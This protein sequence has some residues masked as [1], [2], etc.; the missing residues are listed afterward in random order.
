MYEHFSRTLRSTGS[1]MKTTTAQSLSFQNGKD[2]LPIQS[3]Q[4]NK[5][6]AKAGEHYRIVKRKG[7]ETQ[8]LGDV[9][10][11]K[12]G[13]D[14][15]LSY[16]D[17]TRVTLEN[18]YGECA[19]ATA[20]DLTL[21]GNDPDGYSLN[22][23]SLASETLG[24]DGSSLLYAHGNRDVLIGMAQGNSALLSTLSGIEGAEITYIPAASSGISSLGLLGLGLL[25]GAVLIG[26]TGGSSNSGGANTGTSGTSTPSTEPPSTATPDASHVV[27]GTIIAGPVIAGHSLT[28][29]LYKAD[30]T[31][32]LGTG[33]VDATGSFSIDV[34][35]YTGAVIAKVVDAS[36][37]PD[38]MD[39]ATGAAKDLNANL[40]AVAVVAGGVTTMNINPVTTIAAIKAGLAADGS[41]SVSSASVLEAN[42]AVGAAFGVENIITT[43][44]ATTVD[45]NGSANPSYNPA[46]GVISASEK[47]GALL[48]VLSGN[49][50]G[51]AGNMQATI[52]NYAFSITGTAAASTLD[53]AG[54]A[55]FERG[56]AA[57]KQRT[58]GDVASIFDTSPPV[59]SIS[60][61]A[62]E[63]AKAEGGNLL[64]NQE[65]SF[66]ICRSNGNTA[67]SVDYVITGVPDS[68]GRVGAEVSDFGLGTNVFMPS[69]TVNFAAG[70]I[71]KVISIRVAGDSATEWDEKFA[72]TLKS[73]TGGI[74]DSNAS[75]QATILNDD[76][77]ALGLFSRMGEH[78]IGDRSKLNSSTNMVEL[79]DTAGEYRTLFEMSAASYL[80]IQELAR[81]PGMEAKTELQLKSEA[82]LLKLNS[83]ADLKRIGM[84]FSISAEDLGL[85]L[86]AVDAGSGIHYANG[87]YSSFDDTRIDESSVALIGRSDDALFLAFRGTDIFG[88]MIADPFFMDLHYNEYQPLFSGISNYLLANRNITDVFITGHSLGGEMA[89]LFMQTHLD[90]AGLKY[91]SITFEA[92]NKL[93]GDNTQDSRAINFEMRDDTVPDLAVF[94]YGN[95]G[96][97]VYMDYEEPYG[98][99]LGAVYLISNAHYM[100]NLDDQI[101]RVFNRIEA[102][103]LMPNSARIYVDDNND[104][105]IVTNSGTD[106][107]IGSVEDAVEYADTAYSVNTV[108]SS[109]GSCLVIQPLTDRP[110]G[111]YELSEK[112]VQTVILSSNTNL[113]INA[114]VADH[115]LLLVGSGGNNFII[116]SSHDDILVGSGDKDL[117]CGGV[118][119]DVLYGGN[120]NNLYGIFN[121]P[122]V[123][124]PWESAPIANH[125]EIQK[126]LDDYA[127]K[128]ILDDVSYLCGGGGLDTLVGSNDNDYFFIDV[129]KDNNT[130]NTDT[131]V[132]FESSIDHDYLIFSAAQLGIDASKLNAWGWGYQTIGLEDSWQNRPGSLVA[133]QAPD[134]F[135]AHSDYEEHFFKVASIADYKINPSNHYLNDGDNLTMFVDPADEKPAFVLDES[136][137]D[138]YFDADGNMDYGDQ[139]LVA[140][141]SPSVTSSFDASRLL[142]LPTFGVFSKDL[143][144]SPSSDLPINNNPVGTVSFSGV[145]AQNQT[146]TASNNL[147]DADGL[148]GVG[149]L[150]QISADGVSGWSNIGTNASTLSVTANALN[151][152]LRVLAQYT[153]NLGTSET[154]ISASQFIPPDTTLPVVT[155]TNTTTGTATGPIVY[156]FTFSEAV[157]GFTIDDIALS[158][159]T[160]TGFVAVDDRHYT[161]TVNPPAGSGNLMVGVLPDAVLDASGNANIGTTSEPQAYA[162]ADVSPTVYSHNGHT[163]MLTTQPMTWTQAEA[164]AVIK[165]GHLV[166]INDQ[167]EQDWLTSTFA[168]EASLWMGLTDSEEEGNWKWVSGEISTYSNWRQ[169]QPD[170]GAGR[171]GGEEYGQFDANGND[172][173]S[174]NDLPNAGLN[175]TIGL[176]GVIEI[177]S[178][179]TDYTPGQATIDLGDYGKLIA[180]VHVDGNWYYAWDMNG[181]GEHNSAKD[182]TGKL[183]YSGTE[184]NAAGSGYQYDHMTHDVLDGIFKF[185][186]DFSTQNPDPESDT[187]NTYRF[188]EIDGVWLALPTI[189]DG[190]EYLFDW[191][192]KPS[193]A[194]DNNPV[195]E[196]NPAYD[197]L[198]AI[199]D[200]HNGSGTETAVNGTPAGWLYELYWSATPSTEGEH[201]LLNS[202]AGSVNPYPEH[203]RYYAAVQVLATNADTTVP[204]LAITGKAGTVTTASTT[205]TFQ[206]NEAVTG[207]DVNDITLAGSG[208]KGTFTAV[209]ADTYTLAVT[210][211][212]GNGTLS[213]DVNHQTGGIIDG[214]GNALGDVAGA[215]QAYAIRASTYTPGQPII[216]L[217]DYG[218]LILPVHVD[219]NWYY[220]WDMNGDGAHNYAK[221]T[222]GKLGY[223]GTEINAAGSGYQYDYMSHDG[224]DSIFKFSADFSTQ[225]PAGADTNNTYR[226]AEIDGVK[227]ALPT[228]GDGSESVLG[229]G[230][231]FRP[232][233]EVDNNP[234]GESNPSYDDLLAIWDAHNGSGTGENTYR[235]DGTPAGW[236]GG[237]YLSATP[238]MNGH[239][240][241]DSGGYGSVDRYDHSVGFPAVQ[242]L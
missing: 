162:P 5:F 142:L 219:G 72:I 144:G 24:S 168:E 95:Y 237:Y 141:L 85:T 51:N 236:G 49:D 64:I 149:Y 232:G 32:L 40:M 194:V 158:A 124:L 9:V 44:P 108:F 103:K 99:D 242:V 68:E 140:K 179:P 201:T 100:F 38:Y 73:P 147:T 113:N 225:N 186:S 47:Y 228:F 189:G 166:T 60:A 193:T 35:S 45:A 89:S 30:G 200:A 211:L 55:E 215:T 18:Y 196:N 50:R 76:L 170:D 192:Y 122:A 199:W 126:S 222:T 138:L 145:L 28:V 111:T 97:S 107:V 164:E 176:N 65:F 4:L 165:G 157:T 110:A 180:P 94:P 214:S 133:Y 3:G 190:S 25:G 137:G 71:S 7:D 234:T 114:A 59:I 120:Y 121:P 220:V 118:G 63:T 69:G 90:G 86:S 61:T 119:N 130:G 207:F 15:Q 184:A 240:Y 198:L 2:S 57:V 203:G 52:N 209:D 212:S 10:A 81:T 77:S 136:T 161:L 70:Q 105:V 101:D 106:Q 163:Y 127:N 182:T 204:S 6:K 42:T 231:A 216:D 8:L 13:E 41:G 191:S 227:L 109:P 197:D 152:H 241:L 230:I 66:T 175:A 169:G 117:L 56:I 26:A 39:E 82:E 21:P 213:L 135:G 195:G 46:D 93:L 92:A 87:Y 205:F 37:G 53:T 233:T 20:C 88:D 131:I 153:D 155:I 16:A 206:F 154:V 31:S 43:I 229:Y 221:D 171:F 112:K 173:S 224:L 116:G 12:A 14:L 183:N 78:R 188:A 123:S 23:G 62:G 235:T 115:N 132:N 98:N 226:Y 34:G 181:D 58:A 167:A 83:L 102:E 160:K 178:I 217:G 174:W 104:G 36:A 177:P 11:Y 146:L 239:I 1:H 238:S 159:G 75:L 139:F 29:Q 17:G 156:G 210:G 185:A 208:T 48:A 150:W 54:Q 19:S 129:N 79:G 125:D 96:K 80:H 148:G 27:T 143:G 202:G 187:D 22:S 151:K 218:K 74:L 91:H 67:S 134:L 128:A 33:I 223:Y 84:D 172:V